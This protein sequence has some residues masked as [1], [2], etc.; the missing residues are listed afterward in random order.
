MT[1]KA[2]TSI[3]SKAKRHMMVVLISMPLIMWI[4]P[5]T[6][7]SLG[8]SWNEISLIRF[9]LAVAWLLIGGISSLLLSCPKC[10]KSLFLRGM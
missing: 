2:G 6:L 1:L 9:L 8:W 5:G 3:Y 4:I 10:G 7:G